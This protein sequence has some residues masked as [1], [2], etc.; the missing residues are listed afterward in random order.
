[1]WKHIRT[2]SITDIPA[3]KLFSSQSA[4][5][6]RIGWWAAFVALTFLVRAAYAALEV[7]KPMENRHLLNMEVNAR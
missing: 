2:C 5:S 4:Q 7:R 1:M 3:G 6:R